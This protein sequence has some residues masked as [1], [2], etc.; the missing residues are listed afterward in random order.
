MAR[1]RGGTYAACYYG[2]NLMGRCTASDSE[3]YTLLMDRCGGDAARVLREYAH[4][5]PE[6]KDILQRVAAVQAGQD[7]TAP[8]DTASAFTRPKNSPWGE[9]EHVD[10]L[11]PGVFMVSTAGHGGTMVSKGIAAVLSPAAVKCG[12]KYGGYICFD[13]DT[14]EYIA[15][16]E[17]LD[18]GL[19]SVP[20]K[21]RDKA[22]YVE[23][24]NEVIREHH[25]DYWRARQNGINRAAAAR[26]S[27]SDRP[28][29]ARTGKIN[30]ER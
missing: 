19:W 29:P 9:V 3:A 23:R 24:I 30:N 5:S 7:R 13:E 12:E 4:F 10:V 28:V 6:L 18:K 17:L 8:G 1:R 15:L 2:K 26:Q 25:P 27:A 11:C 21:T 22:A 20:E 16:R 14:A